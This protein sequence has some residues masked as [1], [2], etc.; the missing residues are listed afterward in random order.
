MISDGRRG[1]VPGLAGIAAVLLAFGGCKGSADA[2]GAP[3]PAAASNAIEIGPE[4]VVV[5]RTGELRAGPAISG[6]LTPELSPTVRAEVSGSVMQTK[7]EEGQ[8]VR[9][10]DLLVRIEDASIREAY[11]SA[12]SAQRSAQLTLENARRDLERNQRLEAAG[13]I[14]QQALES[15]QRS[16]S[17]AEA[18]ASDATS[19]LAAAAKQLSNTEVRSPITGIVSARRVD[20]GDVVQ[21]G[22]ALVTVVDPSSMR[23]EAT[24]PADQISAVHVGQSVEFTVNGY[25]GKTFTGRVQRIN[26]AAD[27]ATRQVRI[28]VSIPNRTNTLVAGLF[29]DGRVASVTRQ[30]LLAPAGA[31]DQ[32][33]VTPSVMRLRQGRVEKV[34]VELGV[35]DERSDTF[36]IRSGV[37]PGD[38]LLLGAAQG[39]TPGTMVRVVGTND[40]TTAER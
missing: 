34:P 6:T 35:R 20:A 23:L 33:G 17:A 22:T 24:V 7:A 21:L 8:R 37:S 15:A 39:I 9:K 1:L 12:K 11:L 19:R 5:A 29:A 31:V 3:P 14:S 27:S 38:T 26:P 18:A 32:R 10:G 16:L 40:Q 28:F 30:A 4:N 13:A 25:P 2:K 36:E